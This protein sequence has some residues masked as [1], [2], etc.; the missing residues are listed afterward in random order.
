MTDRELPPERA[1]G[2]YESPPERPG[3]LRLI[4]AFKFLKAALLIVLGLGALRLVHPAVVQTAERWLAHLSSS[5][6]RRV[7]EHALA[8]LLAL[9]PRRLDALAVGA[10]LYAAL[11][12]VEGVGLWRA[13]HWAE[14]LTI[15]ATASFIPLELYELAK[16]TT[17]PRVVAL[18]LNVAT[19]VYLVV[20]L[21]RSRRVARRLG[22]PAP[23]VAAG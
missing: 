9:S 16:E 19:V 2:A 13:R 6:A 22:E 18:T 20:R 15:V 10:F 5:A 3:L 14:Y 17:L 1:P 11:F 21:R 12:L 7:T 4:A 8:R 23:Q